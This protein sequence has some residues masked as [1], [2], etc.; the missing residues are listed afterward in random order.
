[1]YTNAS[2][3]FAKCLSNLRYTTITKSFSTKIS[4]QHHKIQEMTLKKLHNN[5]DSLESVKNN[6]DER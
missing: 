2:V 6:Q 4:R 1:M 5:Y 3:N